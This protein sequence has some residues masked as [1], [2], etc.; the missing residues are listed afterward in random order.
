MKIKQNIIQI[1]HRF[2][3]FHT[4][5]SSVGVSGSRKTNALLNLINNQPDIEK[6]TRMQKTHMK[7]NI[8]IK[9]TNVK[10]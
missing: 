4:E 9:L 10:K 7:Q 1:G 3:I 6:Y 8:N 2:Q 5:N